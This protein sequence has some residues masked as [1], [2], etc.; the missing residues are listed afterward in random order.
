M[1]QLALISIKKKRKKENGWVSP[2]NN[3]QT[4][5]PNILHQLDSGLES[6]Q[7][8]SGWIRP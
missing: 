7:T 2:P 4:I 5:E 1:Q 8:F 6:G 3:I